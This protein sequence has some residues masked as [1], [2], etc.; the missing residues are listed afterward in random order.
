MKVEA[1]TRSWFR[2]VLRA[3]LPKGRFA[4]S[5][6]V[7]AGGTAVEQAIVVL[8]SPILTRLYTPEDFG[9]LA[10]YTAILGI[11]SVVA[12]LRYELAIPLPEKDGDAANLLAL[13]LGIVMLTSFLIGF[14]TWLFGDQIVRW[15][16]AP[17]LRPY[18]WLLPLGISMVG[19]YQVFN[20][21]AIRK[22]AFTRIART[23]LT[24]GVGWVV[25][26]TGL[27]VLKLGPLGLLI[28]R[29]V[30]QTAGIIT[31]AMLAYRKDKKT[32]ETIC[33]SQMR[34][35][36]A[37]YRRFP[38][39]SS[40][41]AILNALGLQIPILLLSV[42][43]GTEVVG[44]LALVQRVLGVPLTLIGTSISQVYLSRA[45]LEAR[46]DVQSLQRLFYAVAKRLA[47][48][49]LIPTLVLIG[50][51]PL[52]FTVAFGD[53]WGQAGI[54]VQIMSPMFL[55]QFVAFPLS[56]TFSVLERQ[57]L[58]LIWNGGRLLLSAGSI[59][60]AYRL[61]WNAITAIAAYSLGMLIGYSSLFILSF[62]AIQRRI[63]NTEV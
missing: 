47:I 23:K 40:G 33:P 59:Y 4:R 12:S 16:N 3:T 46:A 29:I 26:Q 22:Q 54:Y 17:A 51:G 49:G 37:R 50:A 62:R 57:D 6:T 24:Q 32:L 11:L 56:Y 7:L 63:K 13:S 5:V 21:W 52:L 10:V 55:V 43:Y 35:M 45:A 1:M 2:N 28:G 38:L 34:Y 15:A 48:I 8:A 14:M 36:A 42:F 19:T 31:L 53:Q 58:S 41:A 27:G 20:Y 9:V 18:L 44:Q 30:G 61:G 60:L 39:F 25:T